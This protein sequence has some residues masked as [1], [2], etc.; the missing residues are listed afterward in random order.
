VFDGA[1][2][3]QNDAKEKACVVF[4]MGRREGTELTD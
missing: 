2:C 1:A 4:L 3:E